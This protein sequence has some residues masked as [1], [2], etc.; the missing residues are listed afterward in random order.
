[1]SCTP[2]RIHL[3]DSMVS[4]PALLNCPDL[5]LT[6]I[7]DLKACDIVKFLHTPKPISNENSTVANERFQSDVEPCQFRVSITETTLNRALLPDPFSV[8]NKKT[9]EVLH[10]SYEYPHVIFERHPAGFIRYQHNEEQESDSDG[11]L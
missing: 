11:S 1:M 7:G 9:K 4:H 10:Y 5:S 3:S 6:R 8:T 2:N